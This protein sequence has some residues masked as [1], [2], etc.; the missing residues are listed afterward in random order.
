MATV[1]AQQSQAAS[2]PQDRR[3]TRSGIQLD[4]DGSI[5]TLESALPWNLISFKEYIV[6]YYYQ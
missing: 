5:L 3:V 4:V 6:E 2:D 1:M